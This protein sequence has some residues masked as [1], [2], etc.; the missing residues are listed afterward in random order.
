MLKIKKVWE[1]YKVPII[2]VG[3]ICATVVGYKSYGKFKALK[4]LNSKIQSGQAAV[5]ESV[6]L[7]DFPSDMSIPE[8]KRI[9]TERGIEFRDGLTAVID[10]TKIFFVR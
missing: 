5:F 6:T 2:I 7:D 1:E 3:G 4:L 10:G 8:I 9:L